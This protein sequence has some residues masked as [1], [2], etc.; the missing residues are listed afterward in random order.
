MAD[1][2]ITINGVTTTLFD[3]GDGTF[4]IDLAT[5]QA[6]QFLRAERDEL[7]VRKVALQEERDAHTAG[8]DQAIA[9]RDSYVAA[10][11]ATI[12]EINTVNTRIEEI[13]NFLAAVGDD[14]DA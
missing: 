12:D 9:Q 6:R 13:R 10:R 2:N 1:I 3:D 8:R 7:K 5:P 4:S 11:T 14:P